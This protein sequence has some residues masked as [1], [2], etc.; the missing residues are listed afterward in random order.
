MVRQKPGTPRQ[1][2]GSKGAV[3]IPLRF[4]R[5]DAR[6]DRRCSRFNGIQRVVGLFAGIGGL[7]LGLAQAG[8]ET[9]LLCEIDPYATSV[10]RSRVPDVKLHDDIRTL[11]CLPR[12]TSLLAAGFPCQDLSQAGLTRGIQ[13]NRSSLVHEV[14]RLLA[15]QSVPWV[16]LE[17]VPFMLRLGKGKAMD[18]LVR[19][20]DRLGYRWAYRVVDSRAFGLAQRRQRVFF[21][22]SLSDDPRDVLFADDCP[23]E[24]ADTDRSWARSV[25]CGF[26]WTEGVRGLGWAV[27][28]VPTLKGGSTI[29]IPSPPA[30]LWP[31]GRILQPDIRDAEALQGFPRDWTSPASQV[32]RRGFRWKLVGNAVSVPV[33]RWIG[34]R[35]RSPGEYDPLLDAPLCSGEAWPTAAYDLGEGRFRAHV[36]PW[37]RALPYGLTGALEHEGTPLSARATAGFLARVRRSTLN[38][39]P[40]FVEALEVHLRASGPGRAVAV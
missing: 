26:Y 17:N 35:L 16:L 39:P 7:E 20:F 12:G 34:D 38:F 10:L 27:D 8:H 36:S 37:P 15:K 6:V 1:R 9:T 25:P 40:G 13:G 4:E 31:D 33:A 11:T 32:G 3:Q 2:V 21:L 18:V 5:V 28:A 14:F 19:E 29:G 24:N 22:A 23:Q 30:I